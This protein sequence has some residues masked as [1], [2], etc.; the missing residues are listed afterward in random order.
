[1]GLASTGAGTNT[2]ATHPT[3]KGSGLG[4]SAVSI[5]MTGQ[6]MEIAVDL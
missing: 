2:A 3:V 4:G 6:R 1:M 5:N